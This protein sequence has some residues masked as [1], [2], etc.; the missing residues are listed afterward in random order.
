[1]PTRST[2]VTCPHC[3]YTSLEAL[4]EDGP[5]QFLECDGC[6]ELITPPADGPDCVISAY[7]ALDVAA[8]ASSS[9]PTQP[10]AHP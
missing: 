10:V 1:M 5:L 9:R 4:P 7:G 2:L 6:H 8:R 3:G